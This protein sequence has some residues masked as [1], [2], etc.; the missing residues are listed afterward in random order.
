MDP[1]TGA[2]INLGPISTGGPVTASGALSVDPS[3]NQM[4][5]AAAAALQ[6]ALMQSAA[7]TAPAAAAPATDNTAAWIAAGAVG[8]A[9][10]G[11]IAYFAMRSPAG[12][13]MEEY[14]A[15]PLKRRR[16]KSRR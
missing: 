9:A 10:V 11:G 2:P 15:N 4:N 7:T 16:R 8:V 1:N 13:A 5:A 3:A 12:G 14:R 6:A